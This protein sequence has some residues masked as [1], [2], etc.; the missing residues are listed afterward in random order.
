MTGVEW[1]REG[2][3]YEVVEAEEPQ[4][5]A[6]NLASAAHLLASATATFFLGFVF[7]YFYLRSLNNSGLW[8]P[9]HVDPSLTLGTLSTAA[10]A[11]GAAVL[12]LGVLDRRQERRAQWRVKGAVALALGLLAIVLQIVAWLTEGFGPADGAYASV[13]LG[14]T[15]FIVLFG[16]GAV[17]WL[18]TTLAPSI[19]Y[20]N[21]TTASPAPG[22][23]SG[24]QYRAAH[25]IA[26]PLAL[27]PASLEAV[28]FFWLY[29]AALVV[30][31]WIILY[32]A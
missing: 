3:A 23:A 28:G 7:A 1:V 11:A 19:R 8:H 9:N 2:S 32:L 16:F 22:H 25:D 12:W 6:R 20:R 5:L 10:W 31:A 21:A 14:W 27:V 26:D 15:A 13:Y 4:V 17:F 24:D 29:F 18:E 30:I